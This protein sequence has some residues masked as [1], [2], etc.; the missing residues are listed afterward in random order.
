MQE[1]GRGWDEPEQEDE[2]S[3]DIISGKQ[4]S[5]VQATALQQWEELETQSSAQS[6]ED[7]EQDFLRAARKLQVG[8]HPAW[9][10]FVT[11]ALLLS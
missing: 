5:Q 3:V 1:D 10:P 8:C 11:C 9:L 6:G 4:Y 7:P 2:G